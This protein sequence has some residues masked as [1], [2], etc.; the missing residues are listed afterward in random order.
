MDME[1]LKKMQQSVRIGELNRGVLVCELQSLWAKS[2]PTRSF[3][4][5]HS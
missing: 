4:I 3:Q 2:T 5:E 1:K